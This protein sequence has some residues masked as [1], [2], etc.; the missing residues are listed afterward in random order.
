MT[1]ATLHRARPGQIGPVA[2]LL[3]VAAGGWVVSDQRMAGMDAGPGSELGTL[4]WF[5]VTW[6]V[7]MA[8]MMLPAVTPMAA[9]FSRRA[10]ALVGTAAF[11]AGYLAAWVAAGLAGYAAIEGARSLGLEFLAWEEAGRYVAAGTILGAGLYQL[12]P[13]KAALLHRCRELGAFLEEQWRPGIPGAIQIGA[14]YG[15]IC[16]GCCW[17]LMAALFALGV[18][19]LTWMAVVAALI[20]AE[21]LLP[22][23]ARVG[24]AIVLLALGLGVALA[25]DDVPGLTVPGAGM[26]M[27]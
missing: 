21:R 15:G 10:G 24:V 8:A 11:A 26:G 20:V 18:M 5:A 9:A 6:L 17:A 25:P 1:A 23:D 3:A 27:P 2:L 13:P 7:M 14:K 12:S 22:W 19:S 4:G 16:V